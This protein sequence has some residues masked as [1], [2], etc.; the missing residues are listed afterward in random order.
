MRIGFRFET[1]LET[2]LDNILWF[3]SAT[4]NSRNPFQK[5]VFPNNL[6]RSLT[7]R[8]GVQSL[9]ELDL[10]KI[11]CYTHSFR[12]SLN[13]PIALIPKTL[14]R[15]DPVINIGNYGVGNVSVS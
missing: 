10:R 3:P 14:S 1:R 7:R 8:N 9:F 15:P 5:Y 13:N 11:N 2:K 6:S 4:L 12:E